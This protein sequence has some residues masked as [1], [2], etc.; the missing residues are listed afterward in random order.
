MP[1]SAP[2]NSC[3][4][5]NKTRTRGTSTASAESEPQTARFR[6]RDAASAGARER[7][8]RVSRHLCAQPAEW[9][10]LREKP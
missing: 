3:D 10:D 9:A 2:K 7:H 8:P 1:E 4:W 5:R 6:Q